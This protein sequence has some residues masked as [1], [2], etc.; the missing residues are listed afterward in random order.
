MKSATKFNSARK[1]IFAISTIIFLTSLII[2]SSTGSAQPGRS[3]NTPFGP[4]S[5]GT[6]YA[7]G[8]NHSY[9]S[10]EQNFVERSRWAFRFDGA[11]GQGV[12]NSTDLRLNRV[13]TR[14]LHGVIP[15]VYWFVDAI[16]N[17]AAAN[18]K[19]TVTA[20]ANASGQTTTC[21]IGRI[22]IN[23]I[24][25]NMSNLLQNNL[26]CHELGHSVGFGHGTTRDS[27]MSGGDNNRLNANEIRS[28]NYQY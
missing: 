13:P 15:D 12:Y 9:W 11:G 21:Q 20:P 6:L 7:N 3:N 22:I 4:S 27:C 28:I 10:S 8:A 2:L 17:R 25:H 19:C 18:Y 1:S 16:H 23:S 5:G 14:E 26:V 24:A